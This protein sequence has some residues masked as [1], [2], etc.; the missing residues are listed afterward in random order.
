[1]RFQVLKWKPT[2]NG[3]QVIYCDQTC[4]K[5]HWFAHKKMCKSLKDV[6]EKQQSEAAKHKRQEEKSMYHSRTCA[7]PSRGTGRL[8]ATDSACRGAVP[9]LGVAS[10]GTLHGTQSPETTWHSND[11]VIPRL[12]ALEWSS[13]VTRGGQPDTRHSNDV[14]TRL[15]A[16]EWRESSRVTRGGFWG[17]WIGLECPLMATIIL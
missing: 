11:V 15:T 6:Y 9:P 16:L 2:C 1:M 13:R 12:T 8:G 17:Y 3:F 10:F 4:Q 5:T 7:V 14:V